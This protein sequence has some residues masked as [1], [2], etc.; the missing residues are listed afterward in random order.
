MIIPSIDGMVD[1]IKFWIVGSVMG[2]YFAIPIVITI[3]WHPKILGFLF[4]S[5]EARI[6]LGVH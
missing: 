1:G 3:M 2:T 4:F 5:L 6:G